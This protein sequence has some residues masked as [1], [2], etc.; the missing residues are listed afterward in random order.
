MP[1][2]VFSYKTEQLVFLVADSG[3]A[4]LRRGDRSE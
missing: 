2:S 4:H 1:S 3:S